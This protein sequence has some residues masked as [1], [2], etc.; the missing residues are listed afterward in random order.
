MTMPVTAAASAIPTPKKGK[1]RQTKRRVEPIY[2]FFTIP[3]LILLTIG[4][5]L[6]AVVG[7]FFSF[8]N[9]I[10]VGDWD[11]IGLSNYKVLFSDPAI[12]QSYLF[13]MGFALVTVILVNFI[14]FLLAVGLTSKIRFK[15]TL[16]AIFVIPMVISGIIVAFIF[17]FLFANTIPTIAGALEIKS[18]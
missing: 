6:P 16:R 15:V 17:K 1:V 3:T 7:I 13:T 8:T 18:L 4:I 10:G 9:Y 2:Y 14:S 5:T 12:L 11:F